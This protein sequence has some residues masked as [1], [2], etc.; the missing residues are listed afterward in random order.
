[1]GQ[2]K[3]VSLDGLDLVD[4]TQSDSNMD[5]SVNFPFSPD[6]PAT[7]GMELEG[8]HNVVYFEIEPGKELGTHTDS[9]EELIVCLEGEGIEGWAGDAEG[10]LRAGDLAVIPPMTA[11]GFRNTGDETARFL[12]VFSDSTNVSEFEK[13]L[14]PLG[15]RIVKV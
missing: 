2:L 6:F 5:V 12:G 8:G 1:M 7:T 14:E 10:E 3:T 4:V 15:D 13:E 11:H 9:P